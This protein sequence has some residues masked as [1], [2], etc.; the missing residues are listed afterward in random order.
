MKKLRLEYWDYFTK[1]GKGGKTRGD[2]IKFEG[3]VKCLLAAQYGI[4]WIG[5]QK[6]YDDNRDFWIYFKEKHLWAECKNYK[7][8]I[9]MD[10][11]A[12]T[13]VMAHIY[14]VNEILFFS[15]SNINPNAKNK[16]LAFGEK[17]NKTILF[18]DGVNLEKLLWDYQNCIP[19]EYSPSD[20][21]EDAQP[22]SFAE[23]FVH[24]YFFK[25]AVSNVNAIAESFISY[26]SADTIYYNETFALTFFLTNN[27]S[28]DDVEIGIEF[29]DDGNDRFSFQYFNPTIVPEKCQ[30]YQASLKR[31]EGRAISL[32]MRQVRY[33]AQICLPKFHVWISSAKS[34]FFAE[35]NSAVKSVKCSWVG[36][37]QLIG[38]NYLGILEITEEQLIGNPNLSSLILTGSSGTGKTRLLS[39]CRN[40]FLKKGYCILDFSGQKDFSSRYFLK[41]IVSFLYEIPSDMVLELLEQRL[42]TD[43]SEESFPKNTEAEK[44][45][46]LLALIMKS[47][48]EDSLQ[49]MLSSYGSILYKKLSQNKNVLVI[50]NL[51]YTGSAFR[52][53]IEQYIYYAINQQS[54]NHSVLLLAFN[55]DYM[56]TA[57]SEMLY[58]LLHSDIPRL[59]SYQLTGFCKKEQGIAFLQELTRTKK[60]ENIDFFSE[61][62]I[63]V[64]LNPYNLFQTVKYLE[65]TDIVQITPEKNGYIAPGLEKYRVLSNIDITDVL[66]KRFQFISI[67]IPMEKLLF[68]CSVIYVFDFVDSKLQSIF[69]ISTEEL[70]CLCKKHILQLSQQ[71]IYLFDHDVIR[72]FFCTKYADSVLNCLE[73]IHRQKSIEKIRRYRMAC[74]VYEVAIEKNKE[75]ILRFCRNLPTLCIPERLASLFY[76]HLLDAFTELIE[77]GNY[78]GMYLKYIHQ[79]CI[80]VRQY[81]GSQKAWLVTKQMFDTIQAYCPDALSKDTAYYRPLIHFSCDIAIQLYFYEEAVLFINDVLNACKNACPNN[82]ENS[83]ELYVLQAIM[84]NRWYITYNTQSYKEEIQELRRSLMDKSRAYIDKIVDTE[85]K[86]LIEYLNFSDEG[87]NYYGYLKNKKKLLNIWDNCIKDIPNMVPEKTLNYYRKTVQYALIHQDK[88][89]VKDE[90]R[91]AMQYLEEGKYSHEP[92]IFKTFFLMAEIMSNLQHSPERTY[93]YN[94]R[95]IDNILQTQLLLNNHKIGDILLLKGVNAYY[96][97]N[98]DEVYYSFKE[99]YEHYSNGE[100]SRYWIKESLLKENVNYTFTVLGIYNKGYNVSCFPDTWRKPLM[101]SNRNKFEA[102]GIQRTGDLCL[103]LPLI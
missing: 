36:K 33:K 32:N 45:V 19:K 79:I 24:L 89:A 4:E 78:E 8:S 56:T 70:D 91:K 77:D 13:L 92:I 18:F 28:E 94:A 39:E 75:T 51:Q 10:V 9:A 46:R 71:G 11:L 31:G 83:D 5:T 67:Q 15:R 20:F 61:I 80:Y 53:F 95:L 42:F 82:V 23:P 16:I 88:N 35:W 14:E 72:K 87:Y 103:N 12:P 90:T 43:Y 2:G 84:Y 58:N 98:M 86:G 60:D 73:W 57:T 26:T 93:F 62:I 101:L 65:E 22:D 21:W 27:L 68:I 66:E 6:S 41:E 97:G 69:Q 3:L 40:V 76:N 34:D 55:I 1:K 63:K 50:D 96:A 25:N 38:S 47:C 49:N 37:T 44:A 64:S 29:M 99:A 7:D 74:S 48:T 100:T 102:S 30:W 17:S 59:L 54:V 81:D 52:Y 85:K